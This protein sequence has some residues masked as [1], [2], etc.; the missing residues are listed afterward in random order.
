[1]L[2]IASLHRNDGRLLLC[3]EF[4]NG[5]KWDNNGKSTNNSRR[6]ICCGRV[7]GVG[8]R[9]FLF[10]LA[11]ELKLCGFVSNTSFGALIEVEGLC[12][13]IDEFR[14]QLMRAVCR[15]WRKSLTCEIT[16]N[17]RLR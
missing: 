4:L 17:S 8:F 7:Q 5:G 6:F 14:R 2:E 16:G 11:S 10:K 3:A 15:R 13:Q 12:S 1:M 9:P